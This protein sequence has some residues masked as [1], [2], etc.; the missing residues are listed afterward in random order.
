M[1]NPTVCRSD[2]GDDFFVKDRGAINQIIGKITRLNETWICWAS[3]NVNVN[4]A[5]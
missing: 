4:L 1:T 2:V 3:H 5:V